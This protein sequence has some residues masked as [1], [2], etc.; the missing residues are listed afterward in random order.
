M[1]KTH[2]LIVQST[3]SPVV[4]SSASYPTYSATY[5]YSVTYTDRYADSQRTNEFETSYASLSRNF[6]FYSRR[7]GSFPIR[8]FPLYTSCL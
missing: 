8:Q 6:P 3:I 1:A 7:L 2:Q 5:V 4:A